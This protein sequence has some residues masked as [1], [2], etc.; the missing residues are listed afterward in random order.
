MVAISQRGAAT[1]RREFLKRGLMVTVATVAASNRFGHLA[2]AAQQATVPP[3]EVPGVVTGL[4]VQPHRVVAVAQSADGPHVWEHIF[5]TS[6]WSEI[7]DPGSFPEGTLLLSAASFREAVVAVGGVRHVASRRTV[8]DEQGN[9]VDVEV[10]QTDVAAFYSE[11]GSRWIRVLDNPPDV[12]GGVLTAIAAV[13]RRMSLFALG[14]TFPEAGVQQSYEML[15][16]ES[17]TGL[18]WRRFPPEGVV[19]PRDV[20]VL[21]EVGDG[22]LLATTGIDGSA[23]YRSGADGR[24]WRKQQV[25]VSDVPISFVAAGPSENQILLAGIDDLDRARYW[26]G[27]GRNWTEV[28]RPEG[29]TADARF[30]GLYA[31]REALVG[32]GSEH[33]RGFVREVNQ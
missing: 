7:A 16:F 5:E 2:R 12:K 27:D 14:G 22:F 26:L 31:V 15:S 25:P 6:S 28:R 23:I 13:D 1:D 20:T 4:A 19:S 21:A 32:T 17:R 3:L 29:I 24:S 10:I 30:T 8:V 33:E 9:S 11:D 18:D